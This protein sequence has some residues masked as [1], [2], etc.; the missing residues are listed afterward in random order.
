[1]RYQG[2]NQASY[3]EVSTQIQSLIPAFEHSLATESQKVPI[4]ANMYTK[5][6]DVNKPHQFA[7]PKKFL[8]GAGGISYEPLPWSDFFDRKETLD[9]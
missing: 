8:S 9:S 6:A 2:I 7:P 4:P 3:L 5:P 1:M